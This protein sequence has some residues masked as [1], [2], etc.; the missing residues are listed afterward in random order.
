MANKALE[1]CLTH[2]TDENGHHVGHVEGGLCTQ[3]VDTSAG[4]MSH[5][6]I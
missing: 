5:G 2:G 1:G 4:G 3:G 6:L